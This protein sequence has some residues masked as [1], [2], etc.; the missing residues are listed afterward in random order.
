MTSQVATSAPLPVLAY[1]PLANEPHQQPFFPQI[2]RKPSSSGNLPPFIKPLPARIGPDEVAYLEL[3][4]ALALPNTL[5]R[6]QLLQAFVEFVYPYMPLLKLNEFLSTV[7]A[8]DGSRGKISLILFQA[9][10]FAGSAFADMRDLRVAGYLTRKEARKDFFQK[11][12]VCCW[13]SRLAR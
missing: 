1:S 12:R 6:N 11:T 7:D 5:L 13:V 2:T 4:G 9:V 3:K 8:A 10:M